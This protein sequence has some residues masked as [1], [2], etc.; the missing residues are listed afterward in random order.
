MKSLLIFLAFAALSGAAIFQPQDT[1]FWDL[2]RDIEVHKDSIEAAWQDSV[3]GRM[4][5]MYC[6]R[7]SI[8]KARK[9]PFKH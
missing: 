6:G 9:W 7:D 1:G 8:I 5:T 2:W 3:F 4:D